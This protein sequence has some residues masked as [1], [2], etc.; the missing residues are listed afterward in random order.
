MSKAVRTTPLLILIRRS[1]I[2]KNM[3]YIRHCTVPPA[4]ALTVTRP[5]LSKCVDRDQRVTIKPNYHYIY[6]KIYNKE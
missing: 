2:N 5:D 3:L 6:I 4:G 1:G